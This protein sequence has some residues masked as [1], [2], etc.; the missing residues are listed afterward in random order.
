[1]YPVRM[2]RYHFSLLQLENYRLER[3]WRA[4]GSRY[5]PPK[6][7]RQELVWTVKMRAVAA[8]AWIVVLVACLYAFGN[9]GSA[10]AFGT[11][12]LSIAAFPLPMSLAVIMLSPI[13]ALAKRR[14]IMRAKAK[15]ALYPGL[16]VVGITGSYG[17]TSMKETVAA[18]LAEKYDVLATPDSVNTPLGVAKLI[19]DR[20]TE[21]TDIL[22]VEMGAYRK[23]DI[24]DLCA[25]RAPDIAILTGINEAH[26]ERFGSIENT[27]AAKFEIIDCAKEGAL[28]VM[29]AD[30]DAVI[31]AYGSHIH[32]KKAVLY[33]SSPSS[34]KADCK[35]REGTHW[36]ADGLEASFAIRGEGDGAYE[37]RVPL[38]GSYAPGMVA[39]AIAVAERL[40]LSHDDIMRGLARLRP[41]PHRL[42]PFMAS[43]NVLVID[44]SYNGNTHGAREAMRVLARFAD[45]RKIYCTPGLV[46]TGDMVKIIHQA[47]GAQ[48][49]KAADLVILIR[50]S[51]TRHMREG[52]LAAGFEKGNI[53]EFGTAQE[54]H[55]ALP[56]ILKEGDVILFQ[57]DWPDNYF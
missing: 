12:I 41:V 3:F 14:R 30:D 43:G 17:K 8:L 6:S 48:L 29:N 11:L 56:G 32:K 2:I 35:P 18:L 57:N 46:E 38:L 49:A 20:L 25:F 21:H 22:I 24:R 54:A 28:A 55:A 10:W 37:A 34:E 19:V 45:R 9:G 39:A 15:L 31:R 50:N 23:G 5:L 7:L 42:E 47:L 26:L 52:L 36:S 33:S 4:L 53:R 51:A 44:D 40:G 13:D 16:K 1:M 27:I